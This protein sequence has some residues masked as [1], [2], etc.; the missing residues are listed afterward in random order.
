MSSGLCAR[1]IGIMGGTFNPIHQGHIEI[2]KAAYNQYNLDEI[3]FIPAGIP[4]HKMSHAIASAKHRFNMVQLAI[5]DYS[6]FS[7]SDYEINLSEKSYSANTLEYLHKEQPKNEFY[8]ILGGDS[9]LQFR[10]WYHPEIIARNCTILAA[11]R[12]NMSIEQFNEECGYLREH[13]NAKISR[14]ELE[15]IDISSTDFRQQIEQYI[16]MDEEELKSHNI[17]PK[18]MEYVKEHHLYYRGNMIL[19]LYKDHYKDIE[20]QLAH[21]LKPSR[22]T[23]S[24]AVAHTCEALAMCYGLDMKRAY[25]AGL[26]HDCAKCIS[27]EEQIKHCE[28]NNIEITPIEY[29]SAYLLHAKLGAF[30]AKTIY[31]ITDEEILSAIRCHTTGKPDMSDLELILFIADYIEPGR[32]KALHLHEIRMEAFKDLKSCAYMILKDTLDY[33]RKKGNPIDDMTE[34]TYQYYFDLFNNK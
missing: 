8:F 33:L 13:F 16:A 27:D 2:A 12:G 29:E 3:V 30:W 17:I 24:I 9:L 28:E 6:F 14:I 7:C 15:N 31:G 21:I 19:D 20:E 10:H 1:R 4:P 18:V 5:S 22:L 23:H 32:D 26:V 25:L 34:K 11:G